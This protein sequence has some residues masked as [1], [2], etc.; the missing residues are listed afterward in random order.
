MRKLSAK[1]A[2]L[3]LVA[4]IAG[5]ASAQIAISL[6]DGRTVEAASVAVG[7]GRL[8]ARDAQGA[9]A[10]AWPL[11]DV[12][13]VQF[14]HAP[15]GEAAS[16]DNAA[17]KETA[18]P[19]PGEASQAADQ[20]LTT[21]GALSGRVTGFDGKTFSVARTE[22]GDLQVPLEVVRMVRLAG[23]GV[24]SLG[25]EE[26]RTDVVVLANGDRLSGTVNRIDDKTV[27]FHSAALGDR[28]LERSR[29]TAIQVGAPAQGRPEVA[30]PLLRVATRGG[31]CLEL[32]S[33]ATEVAGLRGL[34]GG[35]VSVVVPLASIVRIEVIGGRLVP[36]ETLKPSEYQQQS[37]DVL[38]WPLQA[39]LNVL[40]GPMRLRDERGHVVTHDS[41]IG[42]HAPCLVAYDLGGGYQRFLVTAGIDES[43]GRYADVNLV[44]KVDGKEAF[45]A[46]HVKW[47]EPARQ[48][49]ISVQG[50]RRLELIV[51]AGDHFDVQDRV[52]WARA[53]LLRDKAK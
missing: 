14:H 13:A 41:G 45:R 37:L 24:G 16:A 15:S 4:A 52:N 21:G 17:T 40:G 3:F 32:G 20:V 50:A 44:V 46:D 34:L 49:N 10:G 48:I 18:A 42:V 23:A 27:E 19:L 43:A 8:V 9:E 39:G 53:S 35:R 36:L 51:E 6:V 1:L 29:V 25:T 11:E 26:S 12:A 2:G 38:S 30:M 5:R 31:S 33:V 47:Q 7:D 22:F 28:S